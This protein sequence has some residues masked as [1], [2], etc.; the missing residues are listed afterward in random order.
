MPECCVYK[1]S[2]ILKATCATVKFS[3]YITYLFTRVAVI[4]QANMTLLKSTRVEIDFYVI[5]E[6]HVLCTNELNQ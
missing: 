1:I 4:F 5:Y 2:F 3:V 6:S